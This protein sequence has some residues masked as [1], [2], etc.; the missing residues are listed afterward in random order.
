VIHGAEIKEGKKNENRRKA[1]TEM[2]RRKQ[3]EKGDS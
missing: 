2:E 3:R 1:D